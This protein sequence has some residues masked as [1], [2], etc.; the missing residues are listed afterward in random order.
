MTLLHLGLTDQE[1]REYDQRRRTRNALI[2]IGI[3]ILIC[4]IVA[5]N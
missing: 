2:A 1:R 3:L 5:A 4:G